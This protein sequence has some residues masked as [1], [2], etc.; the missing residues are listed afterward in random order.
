MSSATRVGGDIDAACTRC[1]MVL[2]HTILAM[3]GSRPA[4]VRCN[5]C[6]GEHN[7]KAPASPAA[8]KKVKKVG[9]R[10][11][12]A[13]VTSW[14]ALLQGKDLSR[15]RRYSPKELFGDG[16][17]IQHPTF[18][19]GLIREVRTDKLTVVFNSGTKTLVHGK[20]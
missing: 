5:T 2:G 11:A 12:K 20:H 16:E 7:Y 10:R 14:D 13:E 1:K 8:E 9:A 17:V 3:V 4:R 15:A 19:L 6:Q 18:G